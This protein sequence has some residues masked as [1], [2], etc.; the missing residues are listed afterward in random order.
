MLIRHQSIRKQMLK[1]LLCSVLQNKK[2]Q[3]ALARHREIIQRLKESRENA[4]TCEAETE[5]AKQ[6]SRSEVGVEL[7]T[8]ENPNCACMAPVE[9][10]KYL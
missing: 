3:D 9:L 7:E 5:D 2:K 6:P 4:P 8:D 10:A 1:I